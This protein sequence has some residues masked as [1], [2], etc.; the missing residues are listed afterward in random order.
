[1][2]GLLNAMKTPVYISRI[3]NR[4]ANPRVP[5]CEAGMTTTVTLFDVYQETQAFNTM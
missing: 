2:Y 5:E 1:M 3:R 4:D